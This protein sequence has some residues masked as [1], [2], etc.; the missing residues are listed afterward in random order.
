VGLFHAELARLWRPPPEG[1]AA[2]AALP[3]HL[4]RVVEQLRTGRSEKE[5]AAA[6]ALSRHTVHT[7]VKE[8]YRRLDVRSRGEAMAKLQWTYDFM[9][10][11]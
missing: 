11:L 4:Q 9:P 10:R 3:P 7:Y 2:W 8:L 6:L 1:F 5:A